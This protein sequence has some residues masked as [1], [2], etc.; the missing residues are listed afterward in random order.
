MST[1]TPTHEDSSAA[2]APPF[3]L[4]EGYWTA[5]LEEGEHVSNASPPSSNGNGWNSPTHDQPAAYDFGVSEVTNQQDWLIARE[6]YE[7]DKAVELIVRGYN[8][9][10]LLVTWNSLRGFVPASQLVDFPVDVD[11]YQ[12]RNMLARYVS[13]NLNLRIIE[14]EENLDRLIL[15][16]RAAQAQPG[17]RAEVLETLEK[18]SV[19]RGTVTNL[20]DFGAFVDLGG[21]EGLIH[22]SELSW[23]R[24][25]HPRD[26]LDSGKEVEVSESTEA[27]SV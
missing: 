9:G 23:G 10:G 20:C 1:E 7:K 14:L 27:K 18:G 19:C 17:Q 16:E 15:S 25:G 12:R 11:E 5:L 3:D 21:V 4:D 24:V 2:P 13:R 6:T 8:Q 22:I 26:V